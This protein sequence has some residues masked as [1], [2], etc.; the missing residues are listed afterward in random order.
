MALI[1]GMTLA[2][3]YLGI[4]YF[5]GRII[6][7]QGAINMPKTENRIQIKTPL[8]KK[9]FTIRDKH[10]P[11]RNNEAKAWKIENEEND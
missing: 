11:V 4:G 10:K 2:G 1:A 9:A 3:V 7:N 5:I 6:S 8:S